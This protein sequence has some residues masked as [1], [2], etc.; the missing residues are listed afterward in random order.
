MPRRELI[1]KTMEPFVKCSIFTPKDY[2]GP[3]MELCQDKRGTF[4]NIDYIDTERCTINYELP[5]S[6]IVNDFFDRMKSLTKG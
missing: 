2:I 5:L 1:G 3:L 6:E 4:K